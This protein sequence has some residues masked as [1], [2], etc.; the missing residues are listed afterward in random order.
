[1]EVPRKQIK[2]QDLA[3]A[4]PPGHF[5]M[6]LKNN[7]GGW[8]PSAQAKK[9]TSEQASDSIGIYKNKQKGKNES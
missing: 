4:M 7:K 5:R 9:L 1:V 6:I 8:A 3:A 2:N